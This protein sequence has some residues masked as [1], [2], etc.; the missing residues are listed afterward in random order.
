MKM[1]F[2]QPRSQALLAKE[3][4]SLV[5]FITCDVKGRRE[6]DTAYLH[7][8]GHTL[9]LDRPRCSELM[10]EASTHV[11]MMAQQALAINHKVDHVVHSLSVKHDT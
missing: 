9:N 5:D 8:V 10:I 2:V 3:G 11:A 7:A 6:V 4:E 1:L